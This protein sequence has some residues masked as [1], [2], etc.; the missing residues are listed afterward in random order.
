MR[1]S[2]ICIGTGAVVLCRIAVFD[3]LD[4]GALLAVLLS[5]AVSQRIKVLAVLG[6]KQSVL[7]HLIHVIRSCV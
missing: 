1:E 2:T 5:Y 7:S 3:A 4:A 6:C